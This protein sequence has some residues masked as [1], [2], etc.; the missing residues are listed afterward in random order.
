M[1]VTRSSSTGTYY[2]QIKRF[3]KSL[4]FFLVGFNSNHKFSLGQLSFLYI[5]CLKLFFIFLLSS[6]NQLLRDAEEI[7]KHL[8]DTGRY[9]DI[10][11]IRPYL[12]TNIYPFQMFF[13][14][15]KK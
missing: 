4:E 7:D 11:R 8:I 1:M 14:F 2:S 15:A 9:C 10:L 12:F 13:S 5:S 3:P 6:P